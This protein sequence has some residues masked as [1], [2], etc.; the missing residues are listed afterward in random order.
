M[1]A[2]LS[3]QLRDITLNHAF[4]GSSMFD[5]TCIGVVIKSSKSSNA[6]QDKRSKLYNKQFNHN[7]YEIGDAIKKRFCPNKN[8]GFK[9]VVQMLHV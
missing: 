7:L 3:W 1:S 6:L 2:E 9:L 5:H 4:W 8:V